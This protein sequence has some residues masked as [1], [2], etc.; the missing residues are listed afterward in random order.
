M[1]GVAGG[2]EIGLVTIDAFG[3]E[4]FPGQWIACCVA[5]DA[6]GRAVAAL[7]HKAVHLVESEDVHDE[8]SASIMASVAV[9]ADSHLVNV[10]VAGDAGG[11]GGDE[12]VC[13]VAIGAG[14]DRVLSFEGEG[15]GGMIERGLRPIDGPAGRVVADRAVHD[16]GLTVGVLGEGDHRGSAQNEKGY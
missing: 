14:Q 6:G 1:V 2:H 5:V 15:R 8:P 13:V 7:E 10:I 11:T 3:G 12:V 16:K 4:A 9:V